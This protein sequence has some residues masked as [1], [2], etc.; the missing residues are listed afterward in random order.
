MVERYTMVTPDH[1]RY[2]ATITDPT[3]FTR[4]WTMSLVLYRHL[5]PNAQVLDYPCYGFEL[6]DTPLRP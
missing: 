1:I 5:E 2:T 4:P 3:V 6:G